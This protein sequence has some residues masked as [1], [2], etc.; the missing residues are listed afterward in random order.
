M[1][2]KLASIISYVFHP[3]MMSTFLF[4]ILSIASPYTILPVGF[5][6]TG[7]VVLIILLWVTTFIIPSLSLF[8]L[9]K[10]GSISS[11]SLNNRKERITP[12]IYTTVMYGVTTYMFSTKVEL[13]V[14]ISVFL[15]IST[16]LIA[17]TT[18]ITLFWKISVHGM[19]I[20]GLIGLLIASNLMEDIVQFD[21]ILVVL[22][23]LAGIVLSA[24]LKLNAHTPTQ[25]YFGFLMG[26][27][28]SFVAYTLY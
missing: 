25:V 24:R 2:T 10:T 18:L 11:L 7:A 15:G 8:I 3:L 12:M 16:L 17:L 28:V 22:F 4:L 20:G 26:V 27:F 6:K 9:K 19:G 13:G 14:M 21:S 5:T 23:I 1:T